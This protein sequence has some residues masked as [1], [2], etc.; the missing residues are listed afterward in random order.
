[1]FNPFGI[2]SPKKILGIDT[3][4]SSIKIVEISRWGGGKTLDNYGEI[5]SISLFK[6]SFRTFDKGS[7]L[8]SSFFVSRA[9]R[10]ILEKAKIRTKAVVFSIPDFSTFFTSF[11]LPPMTK[12]E[13]PQAVHFAARQH[14]PLP[15]TETTL[16]WRL[17]QGIP[18]DKKSNLKILLI[19]VPNEVVQE[20]QRVAKMAGLRL[21][22]LEAEVLGVARSIIKKNKNTI[23]LVDIGVQSTTVSIVDKGVLKK[24]YSF[25]FSGNQLTY[26]IASALDI[27]HTEAEELKCKQGLISS[28]ESI[29]KTLYLLIDPLLVE[30]RKISSEFYQIEGKT[31]KEIYLSGGTANLPGLQEYF[32][33]VL[34]KNVEA[35]NSF[36]DL[37]YSPILN[38]TLQKMSPRFSVAV[39]MALGGLG[40]K[41]GINH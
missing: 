23:C 1:M 7:H 22:S 17:I 25:D 30:I 36:T 32:S 11:E 4:T 9:I 13:I 15:V 18:G 24:S 10:A 33:E 21:Y 2:F 19:A 12:D 29:T 27:G 41:I 35:P 26:A 34:K 31:V 5:K 28:K 38:E 8:L 39:G 37:L 6:E 20:Y 3:G 40:N 14:T 16:D